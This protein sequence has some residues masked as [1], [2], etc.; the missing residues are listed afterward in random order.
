MT[1]DID[2]DRVGAV[3]NLHNK[4]CE[5]MVGLA[6]RGNLRISKRVGFRFRVWGWFSSD[7]NHAILSRR[8]GTRYLQEPPLMA[9]TGGL[10]LNPTPYTPQTQTGLLLRN[11]I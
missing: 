4:T 5:E 1:P 7:N 2:C 11:L 8:K 9:S 6:F 3:S 10:H